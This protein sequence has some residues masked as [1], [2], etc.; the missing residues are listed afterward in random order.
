[1]E[2]FQSTTLIRELFE[3]VNLGYP[4]CFGIKREPEWENLPA[5]YTQRRRAIITDLLVSLCSDRGKQIMLTKNN[6]QGTLI[7]DNRGKG[8]DRVRILLLDENDTLLLVSD[9]GRL[10]GQAVVIAD[11]AVSAEPR[12]FGVKAVFC[13]GEEGPSS[14]LLYDGAKAL[15][16][17]WTLEAQFLKQ[18]GGVA[19]GTAIRL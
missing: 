1:M 7:L 12:L 4:G 16:R 9:C 19:R 10:Y 15:T 2:K 18:A 6:F 8:P 13:E 17:L 3:S 11:Q 14:A 5:L